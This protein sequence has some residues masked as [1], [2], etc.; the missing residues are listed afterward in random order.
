MNKVKIFSQ[1]KYA[2]YK[3]VR[4]YMKFLGREN[5]SFEY[6]D[7][8]TPDGLAEAAY[9]NILSSG[10]MIPPCVVIINDDGEEIAFWKGIHPVLEE[11]KNNLK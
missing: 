4:E 8:S 7:I 5:I 1:E 2:T 6:C 9:H 11:I 10:R 3:D